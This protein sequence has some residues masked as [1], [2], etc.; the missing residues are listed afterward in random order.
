MIKF[1]TF[2]LLSAFMT[3]SSFADE[4]FDGLSLSSARSTQGGIDNYSLGL[5]GLVSMR[6]T[7]YLG[8]DFQIG[9]FGQSGQLNYSALLDGAAVVYLPLG[10]KNVNLYGKAGFAIIYSFES[11]NSVKN[12]TPTYGA[13]IEYKW[14][15]KAV[16]LSIQ[17][18]D[19]GNIS[20]SPSISANL[21]GI[22]LLSI[23]E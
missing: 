2:S 1:I 13:G 8:T 20:I 23:I 6:P 10:S 7:S 3:I 9:I 19:V 17:H 12:L 14:G 18:Y 5:S 21:M 11:N 15:K 16:R 4:L 22:S